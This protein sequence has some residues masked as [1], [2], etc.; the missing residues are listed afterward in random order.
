MNNEVNQPVV[1][2]LTPSEARTVQLSLN[3]IKRLGQLA[4]Y[5]AAFNMKKTGMSPLPLYMTRGDLVRTAEAR[6]Y[7]EDLF[8]QLDVL[9]SDEIQ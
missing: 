3:P 7:A 5:G 1:E 6:Q 4:K 9:S 8:D 2:R